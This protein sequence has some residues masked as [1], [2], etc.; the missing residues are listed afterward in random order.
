MQIRQI[1]AEERPGAMFDLAAYAFESSPWPEADKETY[2]RRMPFYVT[3]TGLVAEEDGQ[4]LAAVTALAMRQNVRG[5]VHDMAG[6]ASVV[7][8]PSARR[9]GFVRQLLT[10]LLEQTREQGCVVSALYPFRPSFY[11]HF[12]YVGMPRVRTAT[13]APEG[14]AHLVRAEL[15]GEVERLPFAAA[16]DEFD[17]LTLRL[18]EE[19]HGFAV[20][21]ETRTAEFRERTKRWVAI[22]RSGGEV[23]GAVIYRIDEYGGDLIAEDLLTTGPLGRAL[24]LQYF[25]RHVDQVARVTMKIGADEVPDL[26]GT[27]F[28]VVT[29]GRTDYPKHGGPMV[30]L[31]SM[32]ALNGLHTRADLGVTV[33]VIDDDLLGGRYRITGEAGTLTV[34]ETKDEPQATLTCAGIS[35]LAYGVLDPVEVVLRGFGQ[36]DAGAVETLGALFPKQMPYLFADF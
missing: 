23:V 32:T 6:V 25:A 12:G 4:V 24:L 14:L 22:A 26:W 17:A 5:V 33:E 8:H 21:D 20:F 11:G 30:R 19:R 36:V 1:P 34:E 3:A 7:S 35:A 18:L 16:F 29:E 28:A 13:F 10:R 15:P 31:L 2:A 9:R 27:D